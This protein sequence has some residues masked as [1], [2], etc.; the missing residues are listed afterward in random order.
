[1]TAQLFTQSESFFDYDTRPFQSILALQMDPSSPQVVGLSTTTSPA[2]PDKQIKERLAHLPEDLYDL[3]DESHL[4]RFCKA[5]LGE[6]GA[7]QLRKRNMVAQF[8]NAMDSTHFY[9]LDRFYGSIFGISRMTNELLWINDHTEVATPNEWDTMH[10]RD[11]DFRDRIIRLASAINLG[12]TY[13]GI[14]AAGEA[15]TKVECE[16]FEVWSLLDSYGVGG[17]AGRDW[18]DVS[19]LGTWD[20]IEA[21]DPSPVRPTWD[22]LADVL[23]IGRTGIN[24]RAEVVV[25]PKKDYSRIATEDGEDEAARQRAEDMSAI[26]RVLSVLKPASVLLTVSPEGLALHRDAEITHLV[27]DSNYWEI[28]SRVTPRPDL[29]NPFEPGKSMYPRSLQQVL[30]GVLSGQTRVLPKPP[31]S[32]QQWA[33]WS[34]N[35]NVIAVKGYTFRS[36]RDDDMTHP[37]DGPL[38]DVRTDHLVTYRDGTRERFTADR[39]IMDPR[40]ALAARY[41]SEGI[42]V[43]HPFSKPR[44]EATTHD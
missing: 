1:M 16:V 37:G 21:S 13:P 35:P 8:Q 9:D 19:A 41:A 17:A 3:R 40:R 28:T 43:S 42:L 36:G 7:G 29:M 33:E 26:I 11:A 30:K 12:A 22:E 23:T 31:W 2:N 4:V 15:L 5:L 39:G 25:H 32:T 38:T 6:S 20:E 18:D 10:N 44:F 24:N 27:A 34:Y 14:K